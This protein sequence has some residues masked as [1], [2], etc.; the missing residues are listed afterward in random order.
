MS[1]ESE[2]TATYPLPALLA[3]AGRPSCSVHVGSD[4]VVLLG[5]RRPVSGPDGQLRKGAVITFREPPWVPTGL[6][7]HRRPNRLH[8]G[9]DPDRMRIDVNINGEGDPWD[10]D[11][12]TLD[13]AFG[14]GALPPY[15]DVLARVVEGD[16]TLSVRGDT[17]VECW[18]IVEPEEVPPSEYP[19]ASAWTCPRTSGA[20]T[21]AAWDTEGPLHG[22]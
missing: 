6:T 22:Q 18:R 2:Q 12:I 11:P 1:G 5:R 4:V 21:Y 10:I 3:P 8:I 14:P 16:P 17:A 13:A 20:W 19:A 15:G 7:G 9:F